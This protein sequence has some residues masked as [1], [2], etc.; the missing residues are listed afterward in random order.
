MKGWIYRGG[1]GRVLGLGV[2]L[3][4]TSAR[5]ITLAST[6]EGVTGKDCGFLQAF[7]FLLLLVCLHSPA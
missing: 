2:D 5:R 7:L 3:H 1:N 6:S 4:I